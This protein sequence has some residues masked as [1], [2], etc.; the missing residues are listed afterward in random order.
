MPDLTSILIGA[1]VKAATGPASS[2][3]KKWGSKKYDR[4]IATY[5]NALS[6]Y[7][8]HSVKQCS[9]V[10]NILYRNQFANTD[11][12]YV[13]VNFSARRSQ[14]SSE[15][16]VADAALCSAVIH[17]RHV[18]VRG[19]GG[20][21]KTMFTKWTV[22]R[23]AESI[24]NHQ[25]IPIFVELRDLH[26]NDPS[27]CFEEHIFEHISTSR[28]K[29]SL[30]QF[31]EGLKIGLFILVLDA[32]DEISKD[33]RAQVLRTI[34]RFSIEFPETGILLTTRDFEEIEGLGDFENYFTKP[35]TFE[36]AIKIIEKLDY[37]EDTK[38]ALKSE[39]QSGRQ[40]KDNFFLENPLL[41]T[42]LLLT[43][44][45]SK[46]IPTKRSL[47]Y[48]RAFE[49]LYERH[50]GAKGIFKRDH[51][52][53]LP[54]DEFEKVFSTFCYGTY[55]N[56]IYDFDEAHLVKLFRNASSISGIDEDPRLI[57]RDAA[58]STCLLIKEGHEFVF[59][60]RSFQEFFAA[61]FIKNYKSEDITEIMSEALRKG[62]GENI[63]EFLFEMDRESLE[64]HYILPALQKATEHIGKYDLS[65]NEGVIRLLKDL[66]PILLI[67]EKDS[68][69]LEVS[70]GNFDWHG[71]LLG[72]TGLYPGT[73]TFDILMKEFAKK[74]N[75]L[76]LEAMRRSRSVRSEEVRGMTMLNVLFSPSTKDWIGHTDLPKTVRDFAS[77]LE[78]LRA[79]IESRSKKPMSSVMSRFKG[80]SDG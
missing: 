78:N 80:F 17:N 37:N 29:S 56:S 12:K 66:F 69:L 15:F 70:F 3:L 42:I 40:S 74:D 63:L 67:S 55:I 11:E 72:V 30:S 19:R 24:E 41:V 39:F 48:K 23:I 54:M 71:V 57:A 6:E 76:L 33:I 34:S 52:A 36:Q 22:L 50:D 13:N 79:E 61:L 14:L 44:D 75:D 43:Y 38:T 73:D 68:Q 21:G 8:D 2:A 46:D 59:A 10:K 58:E 16:D 35:L 1:S 4:F 53:G 62:R 65:K 32:A 5:T 18:L 26:F 7:V 49:A 45:Q 25:K 20:A 47:F 77:G 31:I 51:H 28:T 60:H 64:R 9:T 27:K